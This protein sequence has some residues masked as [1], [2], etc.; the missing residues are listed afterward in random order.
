MQITTAARVVHDRFGTQR[1]CQHHTLHAQRRH[2]NTTKI[3]REI[4]K[5]R[6]SDAFAVRGVVQQFLD[7]LQDQPSLRAH[8]P[9]LRSP[10]QQ[11]HQLRRFRALSLH[12]RVWIAGRKDRLDVPF[13]RY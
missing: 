13:V 4:F 6:N 2:Q 1:S 7:I 12:H 10:Q 9:G 3:R 8:L 11:Q 5:K